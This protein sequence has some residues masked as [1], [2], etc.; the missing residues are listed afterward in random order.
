VE[1][2]FVNH[3]LRCG[4]SLIDAGA[5]I[6]FYTIPAACRGATV[7][8]FEPSAQVRRVLE[9]NVRRNGVAGRVVVRPEALSDFNGEAFLTTG[10]DAGNHLVTDL[11]PVGGAVQP[12]P[13][14]TLDSILAEWPTSF[15]PRGL[16]LLK[17]DVEG[18]DE[19]L[20]RGAAELLARYR[21]VVMVE[22]RQGGSETR[23]LLDSFGYR[24]YWYEP[25]RRRLVE[26]PPDW[27]G[28]FQFHTNL[29]AVPDSALES[30]VERLRGAPASGR[31]RP[32][33]LWRH[34]D[35][36]RTEPADLSSPAGT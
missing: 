21:P 12:T 10:L 2:A 35:P 26:L 17:V 29:F 24:A 31:A 15:D 22:T 33:L 32:K 3:L 1:Q 13:V 19:A 23:Q 5:N 14:R 34:V 18:A 7:V 4:D 30:V 11:S 36:S 8:T 16:L 6:G 9:A 20:L 28:N 27:S 25:C